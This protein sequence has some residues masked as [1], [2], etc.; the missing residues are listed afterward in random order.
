MNRI[1]YALFL[2]CSIQLLHAQV[3]TDTDGMPDDWED[4]NGL[5]R[6]DPADAWADA[7]G[8]MTVNLHEYLLQSDPQ[9][10]GSPAVLQLIPGQDLE[11][12]MESAPRGSVVRVPEGNYT[13]NYE[14]FSRNGEL[15]LMLQGGWNE[16]FT[17]YDPCAYTTLLENGGRFEIL[18]VLGD[19]LDVYLIAEG[20]AFRHS[21]GISAVV[22]YSMLNGSGALVIKDCTFENSAMTN[23]GESIDL[24]LRA[25]SNVDSW[26]V[27]TRI[28]NNL[29]TGIV[30]TSIDS[31]Y[32][33]IRVYHTTVYGNVDEGSIISGGGLDAGASGGSTME[34]DVANSIFYGNEEFDFEL[35]GFSGGIV[36]AEVR[37]S[38]VEVVDEI[39]EVVVMST[40]LSGD[41]PEF[42]DPGAG[43]FTLAPGSQ[44]RGAGVD[45]GLSVP[46]LDLGSIVCSGLSTSVSKVSPVKVLELLPNPV[47]DRF[48]LTFELDQAQTLQVRLF[49]LLGQVQREWPALHLP[50]GAQRVDFDIPRLSRGTYLLQLQGEGRSVVTKVSVQ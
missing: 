19:S 34:L 5:D 3:D 9:D 49:N 26:I 42:A 18:G 7:D 37:S 46:S 25:N 30:A 6:E 15:R 16:S 33:R 22:G 43:D 2:S 29:G 32:G 45:L 13:L 31:A 40:D 23:S 20:L 21:D 44:A 50:A 12:L 8:D 38:I 27:N 39:G 10:D 24:F 47:R 14:Y 35:H 1:I 41:N 28:V 17:E 4:A 48:Q 11:Q 36:D